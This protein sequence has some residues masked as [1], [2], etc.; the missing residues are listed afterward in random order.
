MLTFG[1]LEIQF[2]EKNKEL[3]FAL[4]IKDYEK[5]I[6]IIIE[7]N[8][9]CK[10]LYEESTDYSNKQ[11]WLNNANKLKKIYSECKTELEKQGIKEPAIPVKKTNQVKKASPSK[12]ATIE[13]PKDKSNKAIPDDMYIVNDIDVRQFL[14]EQADEEVTFDDVL[15]LDD[16]KRMISR[17][18]F[19]SDY[20]KKFDEY[21]GKKNKKFILLYGVPGTGKTYFAK[22]ISNELKKR[23]EGDVLFF[24][25]NCA[26][27]KDSKVG[28]S[29]KNLQAIFDFTKQFERTILFFD[30][31][32]MIAVSRQKETGDPTAVSI[33]N[34]L[35][36]AINGFNSNENNLVIAGTN[37]PEKLDSAILSRVGQEIEI[38]L[39]SEEVICQMLNKR[40]SK[41][42]ATDVDL[43]LYAEKLI[44][45]SSRDVNEYINYLIDRLRNELIEAEAN[46]SLNYEEGEFDNYKITNQMLED[47]LKSNK[48]RVTKY[49]LAR[50]AAFS[51]KNFK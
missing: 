28:A 49:D 11:K 1:N 42:V 48:S 16:A 17:E 40:I 12:K 27:I 29:E 8:E 4:N 20:I 32:D 36:Q 47:G 15:G 3:K 41:L 5:A 2:A 13:E 21:I 22:A 45:Y 7:A 9:I 25:V 39:P 6:S 43:K 23:S 46:N 37:Y 34:I 33:T 31:F 18:F 10:R 38:G 50:I 35:L 44:G 51:N 19:V 24:A 26:N 14:I 30:E